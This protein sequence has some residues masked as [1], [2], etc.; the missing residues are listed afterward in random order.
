M[1][2][3]IE[4]LDEAIDARDEEIEEIQDELMEARQNLIV[5]RHRPDYPWNL[6]I[7][8]NNH[9]FAFFYSLDHID[10]ES[11]GCTTYPLLAFS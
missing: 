8:S 9:F 7:S 11:S 3:S 5:L 4:D 1:K 10:E 6:K 2:Q